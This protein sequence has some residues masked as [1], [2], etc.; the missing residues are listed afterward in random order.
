LE[1]AHEGR[2][3]HRLANLAKIKVNQLY[4]T[5]SAG[6]ILFAQ[7]ELEVDTFL[8]ADDPRTVA[9]GWSI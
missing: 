2:I 9:E 5:F 8:S 6:L 3:N 7:S 1:I 4:P